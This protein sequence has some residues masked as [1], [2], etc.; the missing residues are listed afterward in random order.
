MAAFNGGQSMPI[1]ILLV[2]DDHEFR[3]EFKDCFEEYNVLEASSGQEALKILK[4]P[5][6]VDLAILDVRMP[7]MSGIEVLGKIKKM[8]SDIGIIILTGYGSKDV[9]LEALRK[10][11][12]DYIEKPFDINKTRATIEKVLETREEGVES[13][14]IATNEKIERVK[15]FTERNYSKKISLEDA[16]ERITQPM[17]I[18]SGKLDRIIPYQHAERI[19]AEAPGAKLK[20]YPEGNH[21]C[22]NIPYKY[23]PLVGDWMAEQLL[24]TPLS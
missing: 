6:E 14:A 13:D 22:N 1:T 4:R 21:V 20:I 11:A 9:V 12:D 24:R 15:R 19:A 3:N 2:D 18:I 5:N 10:H 16:A 17:L 23:R 7:G 8:V